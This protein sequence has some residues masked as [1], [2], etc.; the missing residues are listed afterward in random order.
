[1]NV[2]HPLQDVVFASDAN[3]ACLGAHRGRDGGIVVLGTGS[4][5][6]ASVKGRELRIGGY[7]FPISDEGSGADV[8]LQAVRLP[9]RAPDGRGKPSP[10]FFGVSRKDGG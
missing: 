7:G 1:M 9:P 8:G 3:V 10:L 4:I 2:T 5:G 6:F